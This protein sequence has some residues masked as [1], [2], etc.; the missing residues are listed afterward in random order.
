MTELAAYQNSL[1]FHNAPRHT[2]HK[3]SIVS[4]SIDPEESF[5]VHGI[6]LR[7]QRFTMDKNM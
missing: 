5:Q 2:L 4:S 7:Y 3:D 6:F 1:I